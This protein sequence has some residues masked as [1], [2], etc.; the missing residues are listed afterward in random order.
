VILGD[1]VSIPTLSPAQHRVL[2]A[3]CRPYKHGSSFARPASNKEIAAELV[4]SVEAVKTHLRALFAKFSLD[5]LP[6]NEKRMRL[7]EQAFVQGL[8]RESEL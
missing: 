1:D 7:A 2:V 5:D 4:L 6:Q 8:V 3:L